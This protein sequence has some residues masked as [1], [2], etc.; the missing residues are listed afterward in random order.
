MTDNE[1][2][3]RL[4]DGIAYAIAQGAT[5]PQLVQIQQLLTDVQNEMAAATNIG[6]SGEQTRTAN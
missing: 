3:T 1:I 5:T 6:V 4:T 2:S